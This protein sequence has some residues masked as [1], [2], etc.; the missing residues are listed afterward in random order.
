MMMSDWPQWS[1]VNISMRVSENCLKSKTY[2]F[3][4]VFLS[5]YVL[6]SKMEVIK[7]CQLF[8]KLCGSV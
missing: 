1:C 6:T 2:I 5:L 7:Y 4:N 3:L 8:I